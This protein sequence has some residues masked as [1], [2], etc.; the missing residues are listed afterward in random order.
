M[1]SGFGL[2]FINILHIAFTSADPKSVKNT[3]NL[4][5]FFTLLDSTCVKAVHRMLMKSTPEANTLRGILTYFI[6]F[7]L[8]LVDILLRFFSNLEMAWKQSYKI[9]FIYKKDNFSLKLLDGT[10]LQF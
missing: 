3:D 10:L 5:V 8:R 4:T 9:N 7:W 2:N 1:L 6:L